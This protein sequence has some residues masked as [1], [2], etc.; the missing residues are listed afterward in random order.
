MHRRILLLG[1]TPILGTYAVFRVA[2]LRMNT[3]ASLPIG[4]YIASSQGAFVELCPYDHGLSVQRGYRHNGVCPD[5]AAPLL[6]PVV[7]KAGDEILLSSAGIAVNGKLLP[8]SAPLDHDSAGRPLTHWPFGHFTA[9]PGTLWVASSYNPR[10]YDSRY[11]GPIP[12]TAL[13]ARLRPLIA[14]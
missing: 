2:G 11:L 12:E 9:A 10:S 6:K 7:G 8:N 1:L 13:R 3:S 5:G 14:W 4:L